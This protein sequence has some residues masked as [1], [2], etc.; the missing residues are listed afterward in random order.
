MALLKRVLTCME[1]VAPLSL[2]EHAWDNVGLLVGMENDTGQVVV[3]SLLSL[4]PRCLLLTYTRPYSIEAPY[5]RTRITAAAPQRVFLTID[6]TSAVVDEALN[7]PSVGVI[8]SYR[9]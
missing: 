4:F 8:I 3:S 7:D 1:R 9:R 6:F 5:P 2:A